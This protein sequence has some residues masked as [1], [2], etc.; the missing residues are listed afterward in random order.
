[1]SYQMLQAIAEF[2]AK[3]D[4]GQVC[5]GAAITFDDP[6]VTDALGDSVDFFWIDTE[7]CLIT[8]QTLAGH[9]LAARARGVPGLVRVPGS[10]TA[11]I[12]P[13]LDMGAEGIIV[14]QVRSAEEVRSLVSDCRYAPLG[15]R[16]YGPRVPSNYGRDGGDEYIARANQHLFVSV[17]I[18]NAEAYAALDEIA[19]VPGLDSL[20]LGPADLASSLGHTNQPEHPE[21]VAALETIIHTAR[22]AGLYVGSGMGL[23]ADYA[24]L[25]A[26]RGVQWMQVGGDYDYM[27]AQMNQIASQ[28]RSRVHSGRAADART[29]R[30]EQYKYERKS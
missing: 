2:R 4:A 19:A 30:P 15:R 9:L 21:V 22:A 6:L 16:G 27:I 25:M 3:L 28:V 23:D 5:V 24:C 17:Q 10:G 11:F 7:H 8:A 13:V 1:M 12:K 14:P 29:A 18:E 26:R 20:V